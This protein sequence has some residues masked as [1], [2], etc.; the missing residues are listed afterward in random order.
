MPT[1]PLQS[2]PVS[3]SIDEAL[4]LARV[5]GTLVVAVN[6]ASAAAVAAVTGGAALLRN[7][8]IPAIQRAHTET[9]SVLEQSTLAAESAA[10]RARVGAPPASV[11]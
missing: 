6:P 2:L 9:L 4:E 7:T 1:D 5:I 10:E 11:S 8:I 3:F